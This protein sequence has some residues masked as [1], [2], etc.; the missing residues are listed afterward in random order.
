M[1][2][3]N[4]EPPALRDI[5]FEDPNWD[6]R[7]FDFDWDMAFADGRAAHAL[8]H[9]NPDLRIFRSLGGKMIQYHGW[10]DPEISPLNSIS[11]YKSVVAAMGS[12]LEMDPAAALSDTQGYYRLFMATGYAHCGV[13]GTNSF[14]GVAARCSHKVGPL[15]IAAYSSRRGLA[16]PRLHRAVRRFT[17]PRP[18]QG[19]KSSARLFGVFLR[20]QPRDG[21]GMEGDSFGRRR[22]TGS[23]ERVDRQ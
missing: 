11:Y 18:A 5:V 16:R 22:P 4:H 19:P 1:P 10:S 3:A 13:P 12:L 9:T 20:Q 17:W 15:G 23:E 8:N 14:D 7:T 2:S 21:G 6:F